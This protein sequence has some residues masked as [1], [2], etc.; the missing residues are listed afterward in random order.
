MLELKPDDDLLDVACGSGHFLSKYAADARTVTGLD[1]SEVGIEMARKNNAK[2][3]AAGTAEFVQAD[4]SEFP[5]EAGRF[6]VVTEMSCLALFSEPVETLKE[7][8]RVLR[9][10]GRMVLCIPLNAEDGKDHSRVFRKYGYRIWSEHEVRA[11]VRE[12]G[13]PDP[14]ITYDSGHS[15]PRIM[16]VRA[17][18]TD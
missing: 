16:L 1:L 7:M 12:A 5:W 6:S 10:G 3:V 8:H 15:M 14:Q 11:L 2:R 9:P 4:A 17:A 18:K 13:F